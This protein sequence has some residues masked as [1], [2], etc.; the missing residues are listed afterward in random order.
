[1]ALSCSLVR[2]IRRASPRALVTLAMVAA[3]LPLSFG[4]AP[5]RGAGASG[6][7][8]ITVSA[9]GPARV[10]I[11]TSASYTFR[12]CNPTA[13]DGYNL[14]YRTV[15]PAG[16]G[17]DSATP[18]ATTVLANKPSAGLTT[19]IWENTSDL[20][21]G[22]CTSISL[23]VSTDADNDV[24]TLPV[25]TN[26]DITPGAYVNSDAFYIPDFDANGVPVSGATSY[27]GSAVSTPRTSH[28]AAFILDKVAGNNGEGELTRGV[29]GADPKT[30]TLTVTNNSRR[31]T[32]NFSVVDVLP[33]TLEFLGC[34]NYLPDSTSDAPTN[35][36]STEEYTG[37]GP[38][39]GGT[40]AATCLT[41]SSIETLAAPTVLAD[42]STAV[43]GSTRVTWNAAALGA[44]ASQAASGVLTI[45]YLAGIP[46]RANTNTFTGTKPS[47]SS[48]QQGRNLDNNN[49]TLTTETSSEDAIT[50]RAAATG[51]YQGPSTSGTN[52]TLTDTDNATVTAEDLL[53]RKSSV[54]TVV[55]GTVVTN[56]LTIETS[57]YRDSS[58]LIVT[59][60][61]PNGMCPLG[62]LATGGPADPTCSPSGANPTIDIG[63]GPVA[64]PYTSATE[65]ADG[66]W[67]LVWDF[68][69][70]TELANVAHD[71]QVTMTQ[72]ARVRP[73]YRSNGSNTTPVLM[74]DSMTNDVSLSGDTSHRGAITDDTT[75][76]LTGV[77]DIS[78]DTIDGVLP[79]INKRVSVRTG[80]FATGAARTSAGIGAL[81]AGGTV[82]WSEGDPT[83]E[84]GYRPG[85]FACFDLQATFPV[86]VDSAG[87]RID[88]LLPPSFSYVTGSATRVTAFNPDTL[89][90]TTITESSNL[91]T[92]N[93]GSGGAVTNAGETFHWTIAARV[94][95]P[96]LGAA[97]DI[98][99]N[100]L[101]MTIRNTDNEVF[102]FRDQASA[103][104]TEPQI[105]LTKGVRSITGGTSTAIAGPLAA[106]TDNRAV[107]A[108]DVVTYRV[109]LENTGNIDSASTE[110]WDVLPT[111]IDCT[112]VSSVSDGGSC[113]VSPGTRVVWPTSAAISVLAGASI[114][115]GSQKTLTYGVAIPT[116]VEPGHTF[117]NTAGVRSYQAATNA[118]D[119][120]QVYYPTSNID[121]TV[122]AN[123]DAASD[124]SSVYTPQPGATKVQ[125]SALSET[126]NTANGSLAS[127]AEQATIGEVITYSTTLTIPQGTTTYDG[128]FTDAIPAGLAFDGNA[129]IVG[130]N[131]TL[132]GSALSTPSVG[133]NGTVTVTLPTPYVNAVDSGDD[134]LTLQFDTKVLDTG[135][136]ARSG[137]KSNRST[138]NWKSA[139]GT[140]ATAINSNAVVTTI[141]E[142]RLSIA[143]SNNTTGNFASPGQTVGYTLTV[144]N[145]TASDVS[146]S[147]ELSIVD[148]VPAGIEPTNSGTPVADG[149]SV[150]PDGGTWNATARTITW[151]ATT[152]SAKLTSLA[153]A[154]STSLTYSATVD[155]PAVASNTLVNNVAG[156]TSSMP[157]TV[158]GERSYTATATNTI[159]ITNP[160]I[161]KTVSPTTGTVGTKTTYSVRVAVP[162]STRMYDA[163]VVDTMPDGM[164]FDAYNSITLETGPGSCPD[165]SGFSGITP[166]TANGNGTTSIGWWFGDVT[167]PAA[168]ACQYLLTFDAHVAA[169][170]TSGGAAVVAGDS[171]VNSVQLAWNTS[172]LAGPGVPS[173]VPSTSGYT[174]TLPV[175]TAT[176]TVQEPTLRI[177]KDVSQTGCDQTAGNIGDADTCGTS[178]GSNYTYTLTITNSGTS[179]AYDA[180]V[181]DQPSA[182]LTNVVATGS[183]GITITDGWTVG[184]PDITWQIDGPIAAGG[185]VTITYTADLVASGSLS[186]AAHVQNTAD[187]PTYYAIGVTERTANPSITYRT[188]GND[189]SGPGGNVTA[190]SVDMT[191]KFP[192]LTV[193]KT[194]VS[195]AT[196]ARVGQNFTWQIVVTNAS[197]ATID[198]AFNVDVSDVLPADWDYVNGSARVT[199]PYVTNAA[200]EPGCAPS[201]ATGGTVSWANLVSGVGQPLAPGATITVRLA[202][203]PTSA[204]LTVP[205]TGT[206][207]HTNTASVAGEDRT[208]ASSNADGSFA[209]PNDTATARVRRA[210]LRVAKTVT[211]GPYYYGSDVDYTVRVTNDGPDTATTVRVDD[212]LPATMA[213]R[214][215][216]SASQGSYVSSTGRWSVGTLT[217]GGFATLVIRARIA[218]VGTIVNT[219]EVGTSDQW[220]PDSTPGNASSA[221]TED[222]TAAAS[223]TTAPTSL[224]DLV[225]FDADGDHSRDSNEPGIPNVTVTL[226]SAGNDNTFGTADDFWGPDGVASTSDDITTTSTTTNSTGSYAFTDLPVGDYRVLVDQTSL[227]GGLTQTYD[228]DASSGGSLDHRSGVITLTSTTPYLNADFGYTGTGSL[229]DTV[230]VD[231]NANGVLDGAESG[232]SGAAVTV[233]WAGFD[234]T[235]GTA[236][237]VTFTTTTASDGTYLVNDLP[238]GWYRVTI[239]PSSLPA[240]LV[241]VFDPDGT[242]DGQSVT[243]LTSGQ[244]RT[245]M[246]FGYRYQ[247]DLAVTKT[248]TGD[249]AVGSNG[250]YIV[251]VTN[252]GPSA[253]NPVTV[254]DTLPTGLSFVSMAGT[255]F[256]CAAVAQVVTCTSGGSLAAGAS[257]TFVLVVSVAKDA[258]PSTINSVTVSS[259]V[260]DPVPGNNTATDPTS[261]PY[262]D[263]SLVKTLV[264]AIQAGKNATYTL[265]VN[266]KGPS[267][268]PTGIVMTD[269]LPDGLTYVSATGSGWSCAAAANVVSCTSASTLAVN[270]TST[271]DLTVAVSSAASGSIINSAM[272]TGENVG[273]GGFVDP[274]STNNDSSAAAPVLAADTF[275][276]PLAFTGAPAFLL[277]AVGLAL[278]AIGMLVLRKR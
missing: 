135:S 200:V 113:P 195:D 225:W 182:N 141:V 193:D 189:P 118:S 24:A 23:A 108:G 66:T 147:H 247:A 34:T 115:S 15:L 58:S 184:D 276:S 140:S 29:H 218:S 146:T 243:T 230:W 57:E 232:I 142:P 226:E 79:T 187:I 76:D 265:A 122:T 151:N 211:A 1:M 201:C 11:G 59:D 17:F 20:L 196:D 168:G 148:T 176:F 32:N 95:A 261:V 263:V 41:P 233:V 203:T 110:V 171:L 245:D 252:N 96:P 126:G 62:N 91:V 27:T 72:L 9:D 65:N 35:T 271:I 266:N 8:D 92:F 149:G 212:L 71:N 239:D 25:G 130:S 241:N 158:T 238:A 60:T 134:T 97:A 128:V 54:G 7:P 73:T 268:A 98:V 83:P 256:T 273:N 77:A 43:A 155:N 253:A 272:V 231:A 18:A 215:T 208:G 64:A 129:S 145:P 104:W 143:K 39:A 100:L 274:D 101:K 229:G 254:V 180:T 120:P 246:D 5:T 21:S 136:N 199:T 86:D 12:A 51:T 177:D 222:D 114:G 161:A 157:A 209:G 159:Q 262:A 69:D 16:V 163:T 38:L 220:D 249:F 210:D 275:R 67:T 165:P 144:T 99:A 74:G 277:T 105:R 36:G 30:Y 47:D 172:N 123:T 166:P 89:S 127:T 188:Y 132:D 217:N 258:A 248:H 150:D 181:S 255:G 198:N 2:W 214:S 235:A 70:T 175:A 207:D 278:I 169:N 236:D 84:A 121:G 53:I 164:V 213:Y 139:T 162:A 45:T 63:A 174:S 250:T 103:E 221:P 131:V 107:Q 14:S 40:P 219:A 178:P 156:S 87:V 190:D 223:I 234:G 31:T 202:T 257:V 4:V 48:L 237:D 194:V 55:Q 68:A 49:G 26:F 251:T 94:G 75:P 191:V 56:T 137:T 185:S 138:I 124:T 78:A 192:S 19:V 90:G 224:G 240:G 170:R 244:D 102:Q 61:L 270:A 206:F 242:L 52:P 125:Q 82:T 183:S 93:V 153:P 260:F 42:G 264:G 179:A 88:D 112:M 22:A 50:N 3:L 197:G 80:P 109:D 117:V 216:V 85:D 116:T 227:P 205:K 267:V 10:L 81:C 167:T 154:G 33:P 111:G 46:L 259:P 6:T 228:D 37:S 28:V 173:S 186:D 119:S 106:N 133:S 44:G 160:T 13:T 269:D 152:T 204:V